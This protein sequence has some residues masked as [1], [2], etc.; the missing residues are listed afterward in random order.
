M[1]LR[2]SYE[3]LDNGFI[4]SDVNGLLEVNPVKTTSFNT[5]H[6]LSRAFVYQ[7]TATLFAKNN[8]PI[9]DRTRSG[10]NT[11]QSHRD[12]ERVAQSP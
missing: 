4:A 3:D 6:L 2:G 12:E 5:H 9:C 11:A 7:S 10:S 8:N 1:H